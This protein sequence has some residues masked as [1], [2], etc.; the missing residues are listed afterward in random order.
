MLRNKSDV[1]ANSTQSRIKSKNSFNKLPAYITL[2]DFMRIQNEIN[3]INSELENRRAYNNKLK[4][5]S[6][7]KS[8]NW[9]DSLE[10]KKKNRFEL[11]KKKFL[12]EEERKR[13]IDLEEKKYKDI[14]DNQILHKAQ[15]ILFDEQDPV[16]TFNM[17]LMYCDMLKERDYQK[18]IKQRKQEINNIIEKQFFDMDKKRNEEMAKKEAEKAKIE[19]DK[20]KERM[21]IMDDQLKEYKIRIIQDFQ[22]KQVEG[23]LMK[24]QMKKALEEEQKEKIKLEQKKQEQRKQYIESNKRLMELKA[25]QQKKN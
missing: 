13:L 21:K 19:E 18:E 9:P 22:E 25:V 3:P 2:T 24:L 8:K 10:M 11:E 20:K 23:Q 1:W 14:Q 4:M 15:K 5:L 12:E 17:K 6:Q 16:K 7:I